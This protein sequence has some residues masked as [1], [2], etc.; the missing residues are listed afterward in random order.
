MHVL[1]SYYSS[2]IYIQEKYTYIHTFRSR[3][4]SYLVERITFSN[5]MKLLESKYLVVF[6]KYYVI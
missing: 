6:R 2:F 5:V 3:V 1:R 4:M